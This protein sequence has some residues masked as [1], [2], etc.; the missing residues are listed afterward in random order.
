MSLMVF[1]AS[2]SRVISTV[3]PL[4]ARS[5]PVLKGTK[6]RLFEVSPHLTLVSFEGFSQSDLVSHAG[7]F[8]LARAEILEAGAKALKQRAWLVYVVRAA[9]AMMTWVEAYAED[10]SQRWLAECSPGLEEFDAVLRTAKF[11]PMDSPESSMAREE[12]RE[13]FIMASLRAP[14]IQLEEDVGEQ[15]LERTFELPVPFMVPLHFRMR[16]VAVDREERE[17]SRPKRS[18]SS[19]PLR[20]LN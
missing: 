10:G 16:E 4:A 12:A 13:L 11:A 15:L 5:S 2:A 6:A 9:G 19:V 1:E 7:Y 14:L 3:L 20:L 18:R 8:A 17:R